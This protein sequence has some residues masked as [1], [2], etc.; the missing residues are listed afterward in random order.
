MSYPQYEPYP[1]APAPVP[2][3]GTAISAGVLA[4]IGSAAQLLGGGVNIVLGVTDLGT[5]LADYDSTG[6]FAQHWFKAYALVT[7]VIALITAIL[8]SVGAV[9]VFTRKPLGRV[10]VVAGCAVV[11]IA[12]IA[13]YAVTL[14][15]TT[16]GGSA[17]GISGGVGG[18]IG[19]VF[20]IATAVL[21]LIAPTTRW[22]NYDPA[23]A[24][25]PP[26]AGYPYGPA[27]PPPGPAVYSSGSGATPYPPASTGYPQYSPGAPYPHAGS[28][29]SGTDQ[30]GTQAASPAGTP[31]DWSANPPTGP[32]YPPSDQA[33]PEAASP[34]GTPSDWSASSAA[35]PV[36]PRPDL[37]K[38]Q[39]DQAE[40][41]PDPT[42]QADDSV[43]RRPPSK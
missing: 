20:P 36:H 21:A 9:M 33:G 41:Q 6:L 43:W 16:S 37:A 13:E 24:Y 27:A 10:L 35:P 17:A 28:A 38:P 2:S 26:V 40:Q 1:P 18:L 30:A 34:A 14:R 32:A 22:L 15:Y 12:G 5:D 3:G 25:P 39:P 8:L 19:L 7:G 31:S 42:V 4:S 29:Y 23:S 11:V